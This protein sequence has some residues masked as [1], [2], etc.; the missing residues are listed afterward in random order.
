MNYAYICKAFCSFVLAT[1]VTYI[2]RICLY[3]YQEVNTMPK[4]FVFFLTINNVDI[5]HEQSDFND[6]VLF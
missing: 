5:N 3:I 6:V 2:R 1:S 4:G